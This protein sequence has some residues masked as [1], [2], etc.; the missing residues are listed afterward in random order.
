MNLKDEKG[1]K[2]VDLFF[3]YLGCDINSNFTLNFVEIKFDSA[4]STIHIWIKWESALPASAQRLLPQKFYKLRQHSFPEKLK[5]SS[6]WSAYKSETLSLSYHMVPFNLSPACQWRVC[7]RIWQPKMAYY[8]RVI[9]FKFLHAVQP[10]NMKW[11]KLC[12]ISMESKSKFLFSGFIFFF[13]FVAFMILG[14]RKKKTSLFLFI[15]HTKK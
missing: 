11:T 3:S 6:I 1:D 10:I 5:I 4:F 15:S 2:S 13:N 14:I 7:S 8:W 9:Y 12:C